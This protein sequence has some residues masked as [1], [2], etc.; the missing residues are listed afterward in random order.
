MRAAH[1]RSSGDLS[2]IATP[3]APPLALPAAPGERF[4]ELLSC[5]DHQSQMLALFLLS[6]RS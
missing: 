2:P 5:A 1:A 6:L 3:P 4:N